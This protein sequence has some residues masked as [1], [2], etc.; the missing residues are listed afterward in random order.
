MQAKLHPQHLRCLLWAGPSLEVHLAHLS[1][2]SG[3][4]ISQCRVDVLLALHGREHD[5]VVCLECCNEVSLAGKRGLG[6]A[7]GLDALAEAVLRHQRNDLAGMLLL[8]VDPTG[9]LVD[10]E[11]SHRSRELTDLHH[12]LLDGRHSLVHVRHELGVVEDATW[13]LAMTTTEA[14]DQ[15]ESRF[16]L[17]VVVR[18][19]A[20][21]LQLLAG[22]DQALLIW[23]NAFLVLDLGL[24]VV[25]GVR[26]LDI[27]GDGLASQGLHEDLHG[28]ELAQESRRCERRG[29]EL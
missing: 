10:V 23:R 6:V 11:R 26:G 2:G 5:L 8:G 28:G 15:V 3:Q 19:R 7:H 29:F 14:K 24:H 25:N 27:Q 9:H 17:D 4:R 1:H 21:I 13:H 20:A 22:E 12:R 16:L 18:E